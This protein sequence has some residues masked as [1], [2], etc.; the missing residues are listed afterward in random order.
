MKDNRYVV[1]VGC[2]RLGSHLANQLSRDGHSVVVIDKVETTLA[3][4]SSD[5]S[6]FRIVGDATHLS[7]LREAKV[8]DAD[9]LIATTHFDNVNL[10]VAQVARHLFDVPRVLARVFD[11][12]REEIYTS[13]GIETICPTSV[14]AD[15]F[16]RVVKHGVSDGWEVPE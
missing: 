7:I 8:K 13:L 11:P 12:K 1:I 2:G 14:A 10:M 6:G 16:L 9:V 5:F 4:L 15:L 3:D